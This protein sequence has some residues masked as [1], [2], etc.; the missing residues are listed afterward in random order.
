M[1]R[2][3]LLSD[4]VTI[5]CPACGASEMAD[6]AVLA[7]APTIV[8][9]NCGETWPI[10][11]RRTRRPAFSTTGTHA[12]TGTALIEAERRP[13]VTFSDGAEKAWAAK[14]EGDILPEPSRRPLAPGRHGVAMAG[15]GGNRS[16]SA[17]LIARPR[18]GGRG[19]SRPCRALRSGRAA[20]QS[21][22]PRDR[23]RGGRARNERRGADGHR[24]RK[25]PQSRRRAAS[26]RRALVDRR[27]RR[28]GGARRLARLQ[29]AAARSSRPARPRRSCWSSRS[30]PKARPIS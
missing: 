24:A 17:V 18:G 11:Q 27:S 8:C 29:S 14:I 13:L 2:T 1:S 25:D 9:R 6:P 21:G 26:R 15:A 16:S 7:D 12:H 23:G 22:R 30:R 10:G 19:A 5:R 4:H 20:G 28:A 3:R